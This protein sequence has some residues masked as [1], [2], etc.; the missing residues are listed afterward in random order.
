MHV[1]VCERAR[2]TKDKTDRESPPT[3]SSCCRGDKQSKRDILAEAGPI[4]P[5]LKKAHLIG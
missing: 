5:G 2:N 4:V 1:Y 3:W